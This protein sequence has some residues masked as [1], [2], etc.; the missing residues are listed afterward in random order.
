MIDLTPLD[1]RKKRGDFAKVLRGYDPSDVDNFLELVAERLEALVKENMLLTERVERLQEQVSSQEGRERAVQE[2]LVTAQEL[3]QELGSQA[4]REAKLTLKEAESEAS[5]MLEEA[6]TQT[7]RILEVADRKVEERRQALKE[8]ER[9]R[10][11]FLRAF[12]GLLERELDVVEVE[13]GRK[14]LEQIEVELDLGA[15]FV[16][17]PA[18][19]VGDIRADPEGRQ[20]VYAGDEAAGEDEDGDTAE[21]VVEEVEEVDEVEAVDEGDEGDEEEVADLVGDVDIRDLS[22]DGVASG[23]EGADE[24]EADV[25]RPPMGDEAEEWLSSILEHAEEGERGKE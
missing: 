19:D 12:R 8:L 25:D 23:G 21:L 10:L 3:R 22:P 7:E 24:D 13:E 16:A 17:E 5:R 1:V 18:I 14:P 4:Q 15:A 9:K 20:V 6:E 2:A 11:R